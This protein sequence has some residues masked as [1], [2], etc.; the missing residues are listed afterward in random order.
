MK[1]TDHP[2][3]ILPGWLLGKSKFAS[4]AARFESVGYSV[5][6]VDFPGFEGGPPL[7]RPYNL[8]DYVAFTEKFLKRHGI[9]KAIFVAHSFGGRVALKLLSQSPRLAAALIITGTPGYRTFGPRQVITK[10]L[11][12]LGKGFLVIPPFFLFR[13]QFRYFLY[14]FG[15]SMD[16]FNTEGN[17]KETFKE[18]VREPLV[19]YMRRLRIPTLLLWGGKDR[20]V[21]PRVARKMFKTIKNAK[22]KILPGMQHNFPYKNSDVFVDKVNEFLAQL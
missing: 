17:I 22:L 11:S 8:T 15:G 18:I 3:V 9:H 14:R 20:M 13:K 10:F 6:T 4:L 1:Q 12:I 16:Y 19:D 2:V 5:Y 7:T 21:P